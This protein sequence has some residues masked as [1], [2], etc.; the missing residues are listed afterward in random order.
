MIFKKWSLCHR[1]SDGS[2]WSPS[3]IH[4]LCNLLPLSVDWP[5]N[6]LPINKMQ[7][8]WWNST[9]VI[10][11]QEIVTTDLLAESLPFWLWGSK[12]IMLW[13]TLQRGP[14]GR[15][16]KWPFV[17]SQAKDW[18]LWLNSLKKLYPANSHVVSKANPFP[19]EPSGGTPALTNDF[20]AALCETLKQGTH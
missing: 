4:A 3:H 7:Q 14:R 5:S 15:N 10:I 17:S 13:T 12:A 16:W 9:S 6:G 1:L 18:G 11:L 19:L 20:M 8:R 2:L